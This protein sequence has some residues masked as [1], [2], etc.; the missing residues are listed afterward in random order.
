MTSYSMDGLAAEDLTARARI[1][2]AALRLFADRGVDRVSVRD[3]AK[4][5]GVSSGLIRHHFGSKDGLRDAC[6]AHAVDR[7][8]RISSAAARGTMTDPGL[9]PALESMDVLHRYLGRSMIDGSPTAGAAFL[10]AVDLAEAWLREQE[11]G[12]YGD[13]RAL[14]AV[15]VGANVGVLVMRDLVVRALEN[16]GADA[17]AGARDG[18]GSGADAAGA[19]ARIRQGLVDM[20]ASRLIGPDLTTHIRDAFDRMGAEPGG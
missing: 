7:L 18:A 4:A 6:D 9:R 8:T 3:I 10:R 13:V 16:G 19:D 5:A 14:A 11:P 12:Q 17:G 2:D 15:L 1:R 20:F